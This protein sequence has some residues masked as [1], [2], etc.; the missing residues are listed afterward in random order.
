MGLLRAQSRHNLSM[1]FALN[2]NSQTWRNGD[3][4]T[5]NVG[6]DVGYGYGF[7]LLAGS[8]YPVYNGG[9]VSHYILTDSTGA[10]YRLDISWYGR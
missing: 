3:G 6:T 8:I 5:W 4:M 10:E 9:S 2:Y 7:K 1:G